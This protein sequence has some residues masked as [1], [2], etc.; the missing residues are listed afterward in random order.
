MIDFSPSS[1]TTNGTKIFLLIWNTTCSP[2]FKFF[3]IERANDNF[4]SFFIQI[5][6]EAYAPINPLIERAYGDIRRTG[7]PFCA[8]SGLSPIPGYVR[9]LR[10]RFGNIDGLGRVVHCLIRFSVLPSS[11]AS[12]AN[13]CEATIVL[14]EVSHP[15]IFTAFYCVPYQTL[16]G[17]FSVPATSLFASPPGVAPPESG[18]MRKGFL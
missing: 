12:I 16:T 15:S 5:L 4:S 17:L 2:C 10:P 9:W 18:A 14:G 8:V 6:S 11:W 3:V 1:L 13:G 7:R